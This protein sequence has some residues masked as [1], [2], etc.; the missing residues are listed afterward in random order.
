MKKPFPKKALR[1]IRPQGK[2]FLSIVSVFLFTWFFTIAKAQNTDNKEGK[3]IDEVIA[4]V[5]DKIIMH[6]DIESQY[7]QMLA[8][9]NIPNPDLKCKIFEDFLFQKLMVNQA[10]LDSVV[11][12]D[13]QVESELERRLQ[14]FIN[15]IGSTEK[16]EE[17]YDKSISEIKDD[18]KEIIKEQM[19]S[20]KMKSEIVKDLKVTPSEVRNFFNSLPQDS[21]PMV[22]SEMEIG[23][24]V[25]EPPVSEE[26]I[27]LVK[28]RLKEIRRRILDGE[29]F[30]TMAALYSE[31]KNSAARGGELG[32]FN[33]GEL[34]AEYEAVAFNLK[35][36]DVSQVIKTKAGY[37]IIQLIERRGEQIN[38]RHIL[39]RPK[40]TTMALIKAKNS[41]D[42]I[43]QLVRSDTISFE[44][45]ALKYSDDPGKINGGLLIN[46]YSGNTKFKISEIDANIYFTISKLKIGAVSDPVIMETEE[47]NKAY[48]VLYVKSLSDEHLANLK[49]D[50]AFIK[51]LAIQKKHAKAIHNWINKK[52]DNVFIT[53]NDNYKNCKMQFNWKY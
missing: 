48:R 7:L 2:Q 40:V 51:E 10:E 35:E 17:Y 45:A 3:I 19:L 43:V 36:G 34:Y 47:G 16:L 21:I 27:E 52:K 8:Q 20:E 49:D 31:D 25:I 14:F 4:I 5:G 53:I 28:A 26:E 22:E 15:Q 11:V 38:T 37:H 41:L 23:Q 39:L 24:I 18:L 46:P 44:E 30:K 42:S 29:S 12:P 13:N 33:R 6:S 50:Y 32:F 9:G 1:F